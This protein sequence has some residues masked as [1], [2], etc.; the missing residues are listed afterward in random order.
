MTSAA[1]SSFNASV[2]GE[3]AGGG[4]PQRVE[5]GGDGSSQPVG[6]VKDAAEPSI[7]VGNP[8]RIQLCYQWFKLINTASRWHG[9]STCNARLRR[10]PHK[11]Y[12]WILIYKWVIVTRI[13]IG[14]HSSSPRNHYIEPKWHT[15]FIRVNNSKGFRI[16]L[17]QPPESETLPWSSYYFVCRS[18]M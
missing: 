9:W 5:E 3:S 8:G 4:V 13:N 10:E 16:C 17:R 14:F 15:L 12:C 18:M 11:L 2:I 7:Q 1:A 6:Q